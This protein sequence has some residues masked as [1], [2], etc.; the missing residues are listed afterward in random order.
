MKSPAASEDFEAFG[1]VEF[2]NILNEISEGWQTPIPGVYIKH[3]VIWSQNYTVVSR[4]ISFVIVEIYSRCPF[5]ASRDF[6]AQRNECV[7]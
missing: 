2:G 5:R 3:E 7:P 6:T 4:Q 1:V